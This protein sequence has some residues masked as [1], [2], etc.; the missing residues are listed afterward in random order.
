MVGLNE[1]AFAME[2]MKVSVKGYGI[3]LATLFVK[4]QLLLTWKH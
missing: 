4:I 1:L 2:I 3:V